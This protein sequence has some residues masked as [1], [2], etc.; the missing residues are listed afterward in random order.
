MDAGGIYRVG[1]DL[2]GVNAVANLNLDA[3][4]IGLGFSAGASPQLDDLRQEVTKHVSFVNPLG[5][6]LL[7]TI[8]VRLQILELLA[9]T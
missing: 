1:G 6:V 8:L 3:C 4:V 2:L 7:L 9:F 5:E